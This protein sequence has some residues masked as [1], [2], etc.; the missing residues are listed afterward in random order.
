MWKQSV[1]TSVIASQMAAKYLQ[2]G[3]FLALTGAIPALGGTPSRYPDQPPSSLSAASLCSSTHRFPFSDMIGYGMA[4][5]AV[6]QLVKSL[7]QES[8]G[9]PPKAKAIAL[10]P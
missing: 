9:L 10:L 3:G 6:H 7:E 1:W 2:E 5:A 8:S 4:K